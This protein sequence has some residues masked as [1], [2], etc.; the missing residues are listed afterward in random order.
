[1]LIGSRFNGFAYHGG[2]CPSSW[3]EEDTQQEVYS[4]ILV[5]G[6]I[7]GP[8]GC[9]VAQKTLLG[10]ILSGKIQSDESESHQVTNVIVSM[11]AQSKED[12]TVRKFW[13]LESDVVSDKKKMLTGDKVMCKTILEKTVSRNNGGRY[14]AKSPFCE[15]NPTG[16]HRKLR[17]IAMK[18]LPELVP[19]E[20][21]NEPDVVYLQHHA[22]VLKDKSTT[23]V[24]IVID[25]SCSGITEVSLNNDLIVGPSLQLTLK[26]IILRWQNHPLCLVS[27]IAK[28]YQQVKVTP[29]DAD[30]FQS[31]W[32]RDKSGTTQQDRMSR[33]TFR[34][35]HAPYPAANI[36]QQLVT[37][38]DVYNAAAVEK[39]LQDI[40]T[41][42]L[43]TSYQTVEECIQLKNEI[44][45]I[46]E[47]G[48]IVVQKGASSSKA[49]MEKLEKGRGNKQTELEIGTEKELEVTQKVLGLTWDS[50]TYNF[51]Y[52]IRLPPIQLPVTK[53]KV[54]PDILRWFD[55]LGWIARTILSSMFAHVRSRMKDICRW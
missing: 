51:K 8:P 38:E 5:E 17:E 44:S 24:R 23:K 19:D 43:M 53:K 18:K 45:Y 13:E 21:C 42:D 41:N 31:I 6:L 37:N 55:P 39:I 47:K 33:V 30:Q 20:Q 25:A 40:Y 50:S 52:S 12:N 54:I 48:G 32:W 46:L 4:Q 34:I 9:P 22:V 29:E 27:D 49:T 26:H 3:T 35:V 10:W 15:D 7:K 2:R 1:M 28:I 16:K 36:L 11:H 14:V